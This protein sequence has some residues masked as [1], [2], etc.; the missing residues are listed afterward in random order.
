MARLGSADPVELRTDMETLLGGF[1]ITRFGS[2]PTKFDVQDL[3]PLTAHYLQGLDYAE[4]KARIASLGVP[5][6]LAT[7]FW[8]VTRGNITTLA[9]LDAWWIMFRDGAEPVIEDGD[10]EFIAEAMT[11]L[12]EGPLDE[13][14][15]GTWTAAVKEATGRKGKAL[16]MPLRKALT[17]QAHGPEMAQVLPLLQVIR[18]RG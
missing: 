6:D 8:A 9:D 11:L 15:W 2:A 3:F 4:V 1:D 16:F 5:D 17:G 13:G 12:P 7:Q 14:S 10:A 18:A